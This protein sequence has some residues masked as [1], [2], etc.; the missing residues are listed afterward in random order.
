MAHHDGH[1][2]RLRERMQSGPENLKDYEILELTLGTVLPRG[3][4]KPV[5]KELLRRFST[6]RG[7]IQAREKDLLAVPGVGPGVVNFLSLLRELIPRYIESGVASRLSL[8]APEAVAAMGRERLGHLAHEEVWAAFVNSGNYL[9]SWEKLTRGSLSSIAVNPRD[10]IERG[11]LLKASGF[12]LV[13]NHPGG[14]ARPSIADLDLTKQLEHAADTMRL[15]FMDHVIVTDQE[16]YS[17]M[18]SCYIH[19][20]AGA[21]LTKLK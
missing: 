12:V 6:L 2:K 19:K 15:R 21:F 13:H 9:I 14:N 3:D 1:R 4:T 11:L 8:C 5:A 20:K 7:V 18:E 10:I 17:I 16:A